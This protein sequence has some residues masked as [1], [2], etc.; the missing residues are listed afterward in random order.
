MFDVSEY[1][2]NPDKQFVQNYRENYGDEPTYMAAYGYDT[3]RLIVKA[4]AK[5]GKV[6]PET[7]IAQ[8]PYDGVTGHLVM[9]PET[10]DLISTQV[11]GTLDENGHVIEWKAFE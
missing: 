7:I 10:R 2:L 4:W 11:L 9:D 8:T 3:G 1:N 5:S 6:T